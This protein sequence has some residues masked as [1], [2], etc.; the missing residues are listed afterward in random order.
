MATSCSYS[1]SCRTHPS[2]AQ[3]KQSAFISHDETTYPARFP[4][5]QQTF[6]QRTR[7]MLKDELQVT[8]PVPRIQGS[9][10]ARMRSS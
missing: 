1:H 5:G 6:F 4:L 2:L 8:L 9:R 7:R 10:T 3:A